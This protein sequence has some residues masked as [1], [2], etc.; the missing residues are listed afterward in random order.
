[1]IHGKSQDNCRLNFL[2][3]RRGD[4]IQ[5]VREGADILRH[6]EIFFFFGY[7]RKAENV[8]VDAGKLMKLVE[9]S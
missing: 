5:T 3:M 7:K 1:M 2:N 9:G 6:W 4:E 8:S